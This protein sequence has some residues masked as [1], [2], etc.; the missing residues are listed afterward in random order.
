MKGGQTDS[1][2]MCRNIPAQ[3]SE[4]LCASKW[5]LDI[6]DILRAREQVHHL[7][8]SREDLL[9]KVSAECLLSILFTGMSLP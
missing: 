1:D 3:C 4:L 9:N 5:A 6:K 8:N 7:G 2:R